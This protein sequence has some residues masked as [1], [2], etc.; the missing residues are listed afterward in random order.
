MQINATVKARNSVFI[1]NTAVNDGGAAY[2]QVRTKTLNADH[3]CDMTVFVL[4]SWGQG[5]RDKVSN[6][7][8]LQIN[9]V[10]FMLITTQK[11]GPTYNYTFP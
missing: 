7:T 2:A 6:T 1:N 5:I 9:Y 11:N 8:V 3:R 4:H 10:I